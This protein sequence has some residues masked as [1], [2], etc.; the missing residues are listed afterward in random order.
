MEGKA[1]CT[2]LELPCFTAY[3]KRLLAPLRFSEAKWMTM[4]SSSEYSPA[5]GV[6]FC[7]PNRGKVA[8]VYTALDIL[9]SI[10]WG[11]Y[12]PHRAL[13]LR[14]RN[15]STVNKTPH[16][17]GL[18]QRKKGGESCKGYPSSHLFVCVRDITIKIRHTIGQ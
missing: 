4:P 12:Y 8:A 15:S 7:C 2:A 1:C 18:K 11:F 14:W 16:S 13:K 3:G 10:D 5:H 6:K 9:R 17:H